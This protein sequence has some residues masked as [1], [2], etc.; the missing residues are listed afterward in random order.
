MTA[1][2]GTRPEPRSRIRFGVFMPPMHPTNEDPTLAIHRDLELME[3]LD[4]LGYDEAWIGEHHSGGWEIHG[5]PELFIAV[6]AQRTKFIKFG[7]GVVSTPYHHPYMVAERIRTLEHLTRGRLMFGMG[8]GSLPSDAHMLGIETARVRDLLEEAFDPIVRLLKGETVTHKTDWFTLQDARLQLL[9]YKEEGIEMAVAS[10][11]SPSGSLLAGKYGTGLLSLGATSTAG[12]NSLASNWRIAEE[13]ALE[14]GQTVNR[15][16][17]RL[18]GPMHIAETREQARKEVEWGFHRWVDYYRHVA[19]LPLAP[20]GVDPIQAMI[21]SGF[22][23]VGTPEDAVEQIERLIERSGGF[24]AFL[25]LSGNW[26][27]TAATKRSYELCA[28]YVA[29][30]I[31]RVNLNRV[32]S[33]G[34]LRSNHER[35]AASM[36]AAVGAKIDQYM[37]E[38]GGDNVAPVFQELFASPKPEAN[39]SGGDGNRF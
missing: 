9:P 30:Q 29:P 11:V 28:R 10:Q 37:A 27:D 39:C 26:A 19:T 32:E 7:T 21:D 22:A 13:A 34:F 8:P 18:V 16:G 2:G 5:S 17:W 25:H 1:T 38:K 3:Y 23:V 36:K 20:D 14:H 6:A 4:E 31:N 35:F 24:G 33:E 15:K 12:F